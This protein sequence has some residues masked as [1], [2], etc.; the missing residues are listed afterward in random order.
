M[1]RLYIPTRRFLGFQ[2]FICLLM[3]A[4]GSMAQGMYIGTSAGYLLDLEEP[5]YAGR[6]GFAFMQHERASHNLEFEVGYTTTGSIRF[7]GPI[8]S[9]DYE[10][11]LLSTFEQFSGSDSKIIPILT[12]YRF[13][14]N[15]GEKLRF[16][17]G[18]G[19][20]ISHMS[21]KLFR[22]E[23]PIEEYAGGEGLY[24][25]EKDRDLTWATQIFASL[26]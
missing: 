1:Q 3:L 23:K 9:Y 8:Q 24:Y 10:G 21:R 5:Y 7:V 6:V 17:V 26:G 22:G 12:N 14:T 20:G 11:N 4:L 18:A 16:Q 13:I 19:L 25:S 2:S 15:V